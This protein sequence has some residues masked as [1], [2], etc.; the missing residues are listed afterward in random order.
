MELGGNIKLDGFNDVDASTLIIIKKIV[1]NYAKRIQEETSPFQ[2][3]L[4]HLISQEDPKQ[5]NIQA[6]LIGEK[7]CDTKVSDCNLFFAIDK[8]LSQIMSEAKK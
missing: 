5:I 1:G 7:N 4:L 2:E 8:A 6:R 3:L